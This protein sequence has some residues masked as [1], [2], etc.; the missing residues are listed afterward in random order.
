MVVLAAEKGRNGAAS[1]S[2]SSASDRGF[3]GALVDGYRGLRDAK[4]RLLGMGWGAF[5][6]DEEGLEEELAIAGRLVSPS[7]E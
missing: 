3:N 4:A 7:K 2:S 6:S 1:S 5:E